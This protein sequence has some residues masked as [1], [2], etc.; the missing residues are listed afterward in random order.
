[1][2]NLGTYDLEEAKKI[3]DR[4]NSSPTAN[5]VAKVVLRGRG[6]RDGSYTQQSSL[7]LRHAE[8]AAVY[9]HTK[10]DVAHNNFNER[11]EVEIKRK[12][13]ASV[14]TKIKNDPLRLDFMIKYGTTGMTRKSVNELLEI[15]FKD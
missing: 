13:I 6:K 4:I 1:M 8:K 7:A 3:R 11:V 12:L 2:L 14:I 10:S 5:K 9:V 15:F